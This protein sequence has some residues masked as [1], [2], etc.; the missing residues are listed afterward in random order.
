MES[1]DDYVPTHCHCRRRRRRLFAI[2]PELQ[3]CSTQGDTLE[4]ALANLRDAIRLHLEDM[5]AKGEALPHVELVTL[6]TVEV[7]V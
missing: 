3:G 4:D 2:C 1:N 5:I 6:S 7:T